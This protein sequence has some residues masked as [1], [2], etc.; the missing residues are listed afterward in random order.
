MDISEPVAKRSRIPDEDHCV[1][2]TE[3]LDR[4]SR[5]PAVRNPTV[6]GLQ[7]LLD[8]AKRRSDDVYRQLWP[9]KDDILRFDYKV[10]YHKSCRAAYTSKSIITCVESEDPQASC[11][12][13]ESQTRKLRRD[14]TC[15]FNIREHCFIRG[16]SEK[17]LPGKCKEK[18]TPISTGMGK[19][20]RTRVMQAAE[21]RNDTVVEMRMLSYH[22]LFAYDAKY[23]RSCYA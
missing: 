22:D 21:Q 20:T 3:A 14:D 1:I 8:A 12:S 16:A 10:Y 7:S 4:S 17:R 6:I 13:A 5:G 15:S 23:H 19:N 11:S 18:L 2:C 9:L